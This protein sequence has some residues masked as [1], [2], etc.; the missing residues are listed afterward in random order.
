MSTRYFCKLEQRRQAVLDHDTLNGID[1]VEVGERDDGA[2]VLPQARLALRFVKP[3]AADLFGAANVRV[4]GGEPQR[5]IRAVTV[6][7]PEGAAESDT[8]DVDLEDHGDFAPYT[9]RIVQG[10]Q[11]PRPPS[12]IDP[13]LSRIEFSFKAACPS[14]FDCAPLGPPA[15]PPAPEPDTDYLA[16]DYASFR[17]LMLDRMSTV[18]PQWTE[19]N[20]ADLGIAAVETLAYAADHLS[21]YQDAVATEAYLG[22]ARRRISVRRHAR[23]LD[24]PMHDG[25]NARTWVCVTPGE[26]A[27]GELL[28]AH[29]PFLTGEE[30]PETLKI[31]VIRP[32]PPSVEVVEM[33]DFVLLGRQCVC[34][35]RKTQVHSGYIG[36]VETLG[37]PSTPPGPACPAGWS[38]YLDEDALAV[39]VYG[40]RVHLGKKADVQAL[41]ANSFELGD[42]A[43]LGEQHS[44]ALPLFASL[45]ALPVAA[46]GTGDV[47]VA[48]HAERSL[49]PG[50]YGELELEEHAVLRLSAGQYD[51]AAWDVGEHARVLC[52]GRCDIRIEGVL[53]CA[54]HSRIASHRGDSAAAAEI[55]IWVGASDAAGFA[56]ELG[57]Q[58]RVSAT[59]RAPLGT[60]RL[61]DKVQ[62]TGAFAARCVSV[63]DE[64]QLRGIPR[65]ASA[66]AA[67]A[68]VCLDGVPEDRQV[69]ET[70]HDITLRPEHALIEFYTWG[71]RQ[72]CLPEGSTGASLANEDDRLAALAAGDLLLFEEVSDPKGNRADADPAHR[73]VVRLTKVEHASD[74]LFDKRVLEVEWAAEDALPFA[75][76]LW[77]VP[78]QEGGEVHA[79]VARGNIVLADHGRTICGEELSPA[80]GLRYR[81]RL[82]F[83]GVTQS[84]PF[85]AGRAR[86]VPAAR[87]L[88]QEPREALA[89]VSLTEN[90]EL[91][92]V[93]RDL[94]ASDRFSEDFVVETESDG[95]AQLRFGDGVLGRRPSAQARFKATYRIGN[96]TAGNIGAGKLRLAIIAPGERIQAGELAL[97]NPLPARGG[98][99]PESIE[100]VRLYAPQAFRSQRR[101]VVAADYAAL[102]ETHR[103]VQKAVAT[104]RWTGSWHTVFVTVDRRGGR[105]VDAQFEEELRAFLEPYRMMA[106]DLEIEAPRL[107]ALDIALSVCVA[108]GHLRS[109]VKAALLAMF[110]ARRRADGSSGFFHPDRWSFGQSVY[111]SQIIA[112]AM[113]V[114]GVTWVAAERF[115]RQGEPDRGELEAGRIELGRLEIARL[116]NDPDAPTHGRLDLIVHGGL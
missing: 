90:D 95:R 54:E 105:P 39:R 28:P 15:A 19:R 76:C 84:T 29:T 73:H 1:Y 52:D 14:D 6:S 63:G 97:T 20:A 64:A 98:T 43:K 11:D 50:R 103:D 111:A 88:V 38:V 110:S 4:E 91:W 112:T 3:V 48:A 109:A 25:C 86:G 102:A 83:P 21:Y 62:A 17:Q 26:A 113:Q 87:L 114:P 41:Y 46:P 23:L 71:E 60:L 89:A 92:S 61:G 53:R 68:R 85:D 9:L 2:E 36:A 37:A 96:G 58:A 45:P 22:T 108:P 106:H 31:K 30:L 40:D 66:G 81:P 33:E 77:E 35:G 5:R 16:K 65:R 67:R 57:E 70:M 78:L 32:A 82:A 74:P 34:L 44:A 27:A 104:Q 47:S 42:H 75:L 69:F 10:P 51:F 100:Q 55:V 24:Y 7:W 107:V 8:V 80:Q 99:E 56:A 115:Q 12:W 13:M 72:C 94:L 49:P 93:R 59:L 18:M 79:S 101:A 116:D